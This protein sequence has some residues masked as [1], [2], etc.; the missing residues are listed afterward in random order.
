MTLS[1]FWGYLDNALQYPLMKLKKENDEYLSDSFDDS[2][3]AF[4]VMSGIKAVIDIVEGS[5]VGGELFVKANAE[6]GDIVQPLYDFINITWKTLLLSC[7]ILYGI[8][9]IL[10]TVVLVD[11]WLL[12]FILCIA[13]LTFLMSWFF[14]HIY[15]LKK[16]MYDMLAFS[17]L[18]FL[19]V[20]YLLPI[21]IWGASMLSNAITAAPVQE[22]VKGF[23]NVESEL[24]RGKF[25][26]ARSGG[27]SVWERIK[28]VKEIP[29][30]IRNIINYTARKGEKLLVWAIHLVTGYMLDLIVFPIGIFLLLIWFTKIVWK[31]ILGYNLN[32]DISEEIINSLSNYNRQK[33]VK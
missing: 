1:A 29:D 13:T 19:I 32:Q 5:T 17:I 12:I 8:Q 31:R 18:I 16:A 3:K 6:V 27:E 11:S 4:T 33:N 10:D 28:D 24:G 7:F 15:R 23:S 14:S 22:A 21:S 26:S 25:S 2:L 30:N 20:M 9:L